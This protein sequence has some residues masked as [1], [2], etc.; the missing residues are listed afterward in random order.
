[1]KITR[2]L[3]LLAIALLLG[4]FPFFRMISGEEPGLTDKPVQKSTLRLIENQGQWEDQVQYRVKLRSGDL[5]LEKD[6][7]TWSFYKADHLDHS[8]HSHQGKEAGHSKYQSKH[9]P[10][11]V[12]W[13]AYQVIFEGANPDPVLQPSERQTEYH[14]YFIGNDPSK[15]AG[16]VP[17]YGK[18]AYR[19]LY[20]GID[21]E[22]YGSGD[23]VKYDF[24]LE[25]GADPGLINLQYIGAD[26]VR[27]KDGNLII[28]TSLNEMQELKP[29]AFQIVNGRRTEVA[30]AYDLRNN[31]L[32]FRFPQ[33]YDPAL[34]L[35]I[36]PNVVFST[37]TGSFADNW[38]FTATYDG[39]ADLIAG[40]IVFAAGYPV[41]TGAYQT[42]FQGGNFDV[43]LTKYNFNGTGIIFSTYLGGNDDEQPHSLV[44]NS[45]GELVVY[46]RTNSPDFPVTSGAYD[47]SPNGGWDI[48]VT[49]FNV[50]GTGL[51]GST[52]IGGTGDD[53]VNGNAT[54]N[55]GLPLKYNY[56]DDARGEVITDDLGNIYVASST[57]SNNFP[58][59]SGAFQ[60]FPGGSQDGLIFKLN[61]GLNNLVFSSYLGGSGQDAAYSVQLDDQYQ[62]Y[63]AGGT[64]SA[65][66]PAT[67]GGLHPNYLGGQ[68]DGFVIKINNTG[69]F[70]INGTFI[71]TNSYDQCY[72]VQLDLDYHVY[73]VGQTEGNYPIQAVSGSTG[74]Y[75][76]PGSKQ[77]I[78]KLSNDLSTTIYSTVFGASPV[79]VP[80]ISPTAF[81]VDNCENVY[82][83]GW[84]GKTNY[85]GFTI[86]MPFTSDAF[87]SAT[88]GSDF[89]LIVFEKNAANLLYATFW[90][91]NNSLSFSGEH[92][93][94]G[95]SRFDKEGKV[96]Q[97]VC[98][99]CGGYSDFPTTPGVWSNTNNSSNCNLGSFKIRF[100]LSGITANFI[101]KDQNNQ[102]INLVTGGCAPLTVTFDNTSTNT[103]PIA[104]YFWDFN[105][106]GS[107]S[108]AFEPVYTFNTPG[109]YSVMLITIDSA[110]CNIADT[111]FR[112]IIVNPLPVAEAGPDTIICN[113]ATTTLSASGGL[114]YNWS[115]G[116]GLSSPNSANTVA[117]PSV[118]TTYTVTVTDVNG[119]KDT[120]D[121][122]VTVDNTLSVNSGNDT[123]IC[124]GSSAQLKATSTNGISYSWTPAGSLSNPNIPNPVATP[125][126]TTTY[127]VSAINANGCEQTDAVTVTVY[128]VFTIEDTAICIGES[129]TLA[130]NNGVSFSWTPAT[131][132]SNPNIASPVATPLSTTAYT[133]TAVSADGCQSVKEVTV[134]VHP[135]PLISAGADDTL[136][137]GFSTQ[138][139]ASG[140]V[141]YSWTPAASLNNPNLANPLASPLVT[142]TYSVL[143]TDANGCENTDEVTVLVNDLPT[144]VASPGSTIICQG[145]SIQLN[146]S[147]GKFY[148]WTPSATLSNPNIANPVATP[149]AAMTT[150]YV[151]GMDDNGCEATD[152]V[153]IEVIPTPET[154]IEGVNA[155]CAGG[156]IILT[157]YGGTSYLWSTGDTTQSISVIPA[158]Q[159]T[160]TATAF[161]GSCSGKPDSITVDVFFDYPDASFIPTPDSGFAPLTVYFQN[162]T[163]GGYRYEWNFGT[164]RPIVTDENPTFTFPYAG[165]FTVMMIAYSYYDCPD[166]AYYTIITEN[167]SLFIPSAFSPNGDGFNDN[168]LVKDYGIRDLHVMIFSRWGILIYESF[169]PDFRWDGTYNGAPVPEGVY[170]YVIEARGEDQREYQE[171]GTIT[172][173]R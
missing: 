123:T 32:R 41:S 114:T 53:G 74:I 51:V 102:P 99:G 75:S 3:S 112:T 148:T 159:T 79:S 160:Y 55:Q 33:G 163:I 63:V 45:L 59:T 104:T 56:G 85:Q 65:N 124:L 107:S 77:Y 153:I 144:V 133:V 68:A 166:T 31:H 90:G 78:A 6:R 48:F 108:M 66:F 95:T 141:S 24:L 8:H 94:G 119:C 70:V 167:V 147:G 169:D 151:T 36:D 25:A 171:K 138:L 92:V 18:V 83:S 81:L 116:T 10:S 142:T 47:T 87:Q 7:F 20:D 34:P 97:A 91:G 172:L 105:D 4:L 38:G 164:G 158:G 57:F 118:T 120:D 173:M 17:L 40:G 170:V 54:Y 76:N 154:K 89:Y 30:C 152:S 49:K 128:E 11:T 71:G 135:L 29:V 137:L 115:P 64:S 61:P 96:Y 113:G 100:D 156:S 67:G 80:N 39:N 37:Y 146:A 42:N 122:T 150:Y 62:P 73:V 162:T 161:V 168:W 155:I 52:F 165:E 58:V 9:D 127:S 23:R 44:V 28:R 12:D 140:G 46:G 22:V 131:G 139:Q 93:D 15:W 126:A 110:S 109:T 1:M 26:D 143:G 134:T 103:S 129:V 117:S 149:T 84:G 60:Q 125:S 88:D 111:V 14:N 121:V 35:V 82:V 145:E 136:C 132:L 106:G 27:L 19:Q 69:S 16:E 86:G 21:M 5:F 2:I 50:N 98:A 72:F 130:T 101:P 157:A 43:S 13:H